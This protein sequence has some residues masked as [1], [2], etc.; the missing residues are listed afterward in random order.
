[1]APTIEP[2]IEDQDLY[3]H[4]Q[5]TGSKLWIDCAAPGWGGV[6]GNLV[7]RGVGFVDIHLLGATRLAGAALWTRDRRLAEAARGLGIA[8][9]GIS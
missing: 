2:I 6:V 8:A 3:R 4:L 9:A 7:D 1:M 5:K